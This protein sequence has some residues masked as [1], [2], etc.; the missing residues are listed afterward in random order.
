[1]IG[2]RVKGGVN[3]PAPII[4]LDDVSRRYGAVA[5]VD[6]VSLEFARGSFVALVGASGS[7][8]STLLRMI[9]RL[10]EPDTGRVLIDGRDVT[11]EP[12]PGFA[13]GS[14]MSFSNTACSRT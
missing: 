1:M 14:A 11:A 10:E 9:N 4:T 13:A 2:S 3:A 5:A 8:K 7:G 12:A 6:H